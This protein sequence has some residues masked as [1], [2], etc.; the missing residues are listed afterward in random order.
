MI[1]KIVGIFILSI[2]SLIAYRAG[3]SGNYP[4]FVRPLALCVCTILGLLLLGYYS[5]LVILCGGAMYGLSTTYF[6]SKGS[7]A[8][9]IAWLLVGLAFSLSVLPIVLVYHNYLGFAIRTIVC[10]SFI[11]IWSETNGNSVWEEG[12]RGLI[13]IATLPLLLIGS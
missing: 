5:W 4:R 3:G 13:P 6:K 1:I 8:T 12:G 2:I 10:T 7:D 11:I 9:W